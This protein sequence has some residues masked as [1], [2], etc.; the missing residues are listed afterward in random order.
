[1]SEILAKHR[2][3]AARLSSHNNRRFECV[4]WPCDGH[5]CPSYTRRCRHPSNELPHE[6]EDGTFVEPRGQRRPLCISNLK[7]Q[8]QNFK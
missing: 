7:S 6:A 8:I 1:M 3:I 2:F 5:E 4:F